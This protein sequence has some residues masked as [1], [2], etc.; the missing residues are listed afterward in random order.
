MPVV[1]IPLTSDES[2]QLLGHEPIQAD[3][4]GQDV[5]LMRL[6][7]RGLSAEVI[8]SRLGLAPR[9]VYRRLARLREAFGAESTAELATE[10]AR[11]G[12]GVS[13]PTAADR[14]SDARVVEPTERNEE[15]SR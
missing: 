7:A 8:A 15:G 2:D 12:F 14:G 5:D 10:L 1:M 4:L 3:E 13:E 9:S 6:V 11:R